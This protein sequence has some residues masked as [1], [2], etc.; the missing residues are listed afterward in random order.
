M[1]TTTE[2]SDQAMLDIMRQH[3]PVTIS[4]L[5][6][7]MG[8]TATAVR[9]RLARL[10]ADGLIERRAERKTRGRPNHRYSLTD[11]G[12]KSAGT[13]CADMAVVLWEEVKSVKDP[14]VRR[15]LLKRIAERLVAKYRSEIT[16]DTLNSRMSELA[17]LMDRREIPFRVDTSGELP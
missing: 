17:G 6:Q 8:V 11:K 3:G 15:G 2:T 13:N 4:K 1:S 14:A 5:V 9:Q 16:G 7:E 12:E 10:M